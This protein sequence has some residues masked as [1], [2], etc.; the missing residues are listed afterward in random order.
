MPLSNN[1]QAL[2]MV[3][4]GYL[5]KARPGHPQT[6]PTYRQVAADLGFHNIT[7]P[8]GRFLQPRGLDELAEWTKANNIPA[9]TGLIVLQDE[10][11]PGLGYFE[12]YGKANSPDMY[13]WWAEEIK[14]S[15]THD[16]DVH[17]GR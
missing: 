5:D 17:L 10:R 6:Y 9:I 2:L 7:M 16:W 1:A 15:K 14:K 4:I 12:L 3:L 11:V 8:I 13:D